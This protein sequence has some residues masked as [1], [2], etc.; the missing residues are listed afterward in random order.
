MKITAGNWQA[1]ADKAIARWARKRAKAI[2]TEYGGGL[3]LRPIQGENAD[4]EAA[5]WCFSFV[6][7]GGRT[8][9][10]TIG[11]W[12]ESWTNISQRKRS[13]LQAGMTVDEARGLV[14][15]LQ[16]GDSRAVGFV[17]LQNGKPQHFES[18]VI[19]HMG[20]NQLEA[21]IK[22]EKEWVRYT[23]R[24]RHWPQVDKA[25]ARRALHRLESLLGRMRAFAHARGLQLQAAASERVA[26]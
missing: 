12:P 4:P 20:E 17:M 22:R 19:A 2:A 10:L 8:R 9:C 23:S 11:R 21:A 6:D 1:E 25:K 13:P 18:R 16:A 7:D 15:R 14:A 5:E 3:S 26:A 24:A